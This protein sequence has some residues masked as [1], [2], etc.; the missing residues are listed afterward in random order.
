MKP[1]TN[2]LTEI[3]NADVRYV[4]PLYQRPYVWNRER[5]WEPLW[6]DIGV[7]LD[8]YLAEAEEPMRHFLGA[9][10]LDQQDNAPGEPVRR[11]VIDGQ[12]RLTTLQLLMV[13]AA[14]AASADGCERQARLL[15]K[16]THNDPDLASGDERFKVWPTNANQAAFRDVMHGNG[17]ALAAADSP[18]NNIHEAYAYFS[19]A[20]RTWVHTEQPDDDHVRERH[21]ALRVALSG[22]LQVVSINLEPGDNPQV[23]FETLN[24]RGTPLLA[25]DLVKNA[26]FY[27]AQ[28]A[29]A[30][31]DDLN[32]SVWEPELG[33]EY[34]RES[35]R[36]G[37]LNRPRA[38]IFLMH[39]LAMKLGR[40]V[41]ATELFSQF[42]AHILDA[43]VAPD[44]GL[45][46]RELCRD[47]AVMR[48]FDDQPVGSVEERFFRHL[49]ALDTTTVLPVALLLYRTAGLSI[50]QRRVGLRALES[51]L[52]RR[53]LCGYTAANYN[54]LTAELLK[55][56]AADVS[57]ADVIIV[58]FL[59]SSTATT[60]VWPSDETVIEALT[61][62]RLYGFVSQKR[63][64]MVLSALEL[65]LRQS[66]KVEDIY[67]LPSNL[68]IEHIMPQSW[69]DRW[70]GDGGVDADQRD[71]HVHLLGNLTLTSGPLNALLSNASWDVKRPALEA[72]SLL[73]LNRE[74]TGHETW[75]ESLID[76]RG[77]RLADWI[78][79]LWPG[80]HAAAWP[81][82]S[83]VVFP[84]ATTEP[85]AAAARPVS[86]SRERA[87]NHQNAPTEPPAQAAVAA[88]A[89]PEDAEDRPLRQFWSDLLERANRR[90]Q[91]H[92]QVSPSHVTLVSAGAGITGVSLNYVAAQHSAR[93]EVYM[94]RP[95]AAEN[96]VIFD[97]LHRHRDDIE[98]AYGRPLRWQRLAGKVACR[99]SDRFDDGGFLDSERWP[100]IH[101]EMIDAMIRLERVM[102]PYVSRLSRRPVAGD[103]EPLTGPDVDHQS[104]DR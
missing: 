35:I 5:H 66:T 104:S 45:L 98:R 97:S 90:S 68:T 39:W 26:L 32:G 87:E 99:I 30:D 44:M 36:H 1:A 37:R 53:M 43:P 74:I 88:P 85:P 63:I 84:G 14:Q 70:A 77:R 102:G 17:R 96:K 50:D 28:R 57:H 9:I 33:Q 13:A 92:A 91:L 103:S 71:A 59:R 81:T 22:L 62:R 60:A 48:G 6:E 41:P 27:R 76:Q 18:A 2:T 80:P 83:G 100:A 64:V 8:H 49:D 38:E 79:R 75:D 78:C 12:Q 15:S 11:L 34:W 67:A 86:S 89:R 42:R 52:V 56:I 10:V 19:E 82:T 95:N 16:L 4:V 47:A 24:A 54:R 40:M 29:R 58:K 94:R 93:V 21:E 46:I 7:V 51:W 101:E 61:A 3:F 73:L 69:T 65:S 72:H 55:Q 20:I 23:I 25:M 31:V